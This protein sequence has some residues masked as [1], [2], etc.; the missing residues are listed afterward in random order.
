VLPFL[1]LATRAEDRAADEEYAAFLRFGG[2]A[3]SELVRHRLER[4]PLGDLRLD[5]FSGVILG[6]SPF[7]TSVP[8]EEKSE[9]QLRVESEL[10]VLLDEVVARD[11]PLLGACYGVS[12]LG[13]HQGGLVDGTYTEPV[14]AVT[15]TLTE[16]G[17]RDPLLGVLPQTFEAYVGHKEAVTS[18]PGHA[19]LLAGSPACPVQAFKVRQNVYATQFH[20]ELDVPGIHTR[21]EIYKHAG[22]FAPETAAELKEQTGRA[23]VVHPPTMVRRFVELYARS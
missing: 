3:E 10:S 23:H 8:K 13:V 17:R 22:Y 12:T 9:A 16:A 19:V 4:D 21:I 1:L 7:T 11:F 18:L 5:D 6:G 15:V 14:S 20:P 2:L